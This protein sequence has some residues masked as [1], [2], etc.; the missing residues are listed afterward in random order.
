MV[1]NVRAV[2]IMSLR[3]CRHLADCVRLGFHMRWRSIILVHRPERL[4]I[5]EQVLPD[6]REFE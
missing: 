2:M 1:R 6:L 5:F 4:V 3:R